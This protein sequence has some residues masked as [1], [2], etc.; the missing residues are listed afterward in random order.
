MIDNIVTLTHMIMEMIPFL[1]FGFLCAGILHV[2]VPQNFYKTHLSQNN[3]KSIVLAALFGI[4]L[5]LC[6]CSVLPTAMSLQKEGASKGATTAFLTATPQTGVDSILATYSVFG[7]P[8]AIIRPIV[9][10]ITSIFSG[11][12]V[13]IFD[14]EKQQE[15]KTNTTEDNDKEETILGKIK[16]LLHYSYVTMLQDIGG[17][18]II[19]LIIAG[20]IAVFIPDQFLLRFS[21]NP[22]LEMFAVTLV[23]IPM[24]V[25]ATG[26]IPIAAALMIKGLSP[27]A[28]L[29]FLMAGPAVSFAS[30]VIVKKVMGT[31]SM[32]LYIVSII[33][34]AISFGML[35]NNVLPEEWFSTIGKLNH[36]DNTS[37][38]LIDITASIIF[39]ILIINALV[40]H[41]HSHHH[42]NMTDSKVFMVKGM[43]CSHC[44]EN[45]E[46]HLS[47]LPNVKN[48][49]A[50]ISTG[51]ITI[52]GNVESNTVK[53]TI[54]SLGY[55][56]EGEK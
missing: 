13:A 20:I 55:I 44:K 16:K 36:H 51:T 11:S 19:G 45:V 28:A 33:I 49:C 25:C 40:I 48:V 22:L 6:S 29:V 4:P 17:H 18:L 38:S 21:D 30:L 26:S 10:L 5:P 3:F 54:E 24:Y 42:I 7:L 50:D 23:A 14:K 41:K 9:A 2:F 52:E 43:N 8:F 12:L 53:E 34:G 32:L 35:I 37:F 31:K 1:L 46:T 47:K 15:T 56:Y 27:G 39:I